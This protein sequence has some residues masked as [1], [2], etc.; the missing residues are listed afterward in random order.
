MATKWEE[1]EATEPKN[2]CERRFTVTRAIVVALLPVLSAVCKPA[3]D[4]PPAEYLQAGPMVGYSTSRETLLWVQTNRPADVMF[5]YYDTAIPDRRYTTGMAR[6]S[7]EDAYIVK[8]LAD[9]VSPAHRYAYELYLNGQQVER[10]YPLRFQTP[11]PT[12]SLSGPP[13]FRLAIGSCNYVIDPDLDGRSRPYGGD[14][15]IFE[16]IR[17]RQPHLM[18]W[19]GDNVYLR[20]GEWASREGVLYRYT[21][22]RSLPELQPLLAS[23]HH[24][25]IWDDHDFG[26]G[27]SGGSWWNKETSLE[28]F[29]LF[30]G[31]PCFGVNGQ[32]GITCSFRWSDVE[33]F[34]LDNRYY[35]TPS[36]RESG[37]RAI[38]GPG[39]L[40][41]LVDA[42]VSS[43]ATFKIVVSGGQVLNP[44]TA[45]E[46][47]ANYPEER[48]AL[49]EAIERERIAG[50]LFLSGDRHRSEL[51]RLDRPGAYPLYDVTISPL[52]ADLYSLGFEPNP[53]RVEGTWLVDHNFATLD[54]EGPRDDRRLTITA[55]DRQGIV[56][57]THT[58]RANE[59]R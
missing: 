9:S 31:N 51:S 53:L 54:F 7:K 32:P 41:W 47:Y 24:Y 26:P 5:I 36:D 8:I 44:Y 10:P 29:T 2:R 15:Q 14:Y 55:I 21:H 17:A 11:P 33:F 48:A 30:W 50:V 58:I 59:L 42:L 16:H 39:Q 45:P 23:T 57:W 3:S 18:I 49:L 22:T 25:A 37:D 38:Q 12:R 43:E 46:N 19:L 28:A 13:S 1:E 52:T 56:R 40:Q 27:D 35:R 4:A 6:T 20:Q 34:L